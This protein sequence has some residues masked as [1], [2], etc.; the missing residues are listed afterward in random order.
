[1]RA[2]MPNMRQIAPPITASTR[3]A[4]YPFTH[5]IT[6]APDGMRNSQMIENMTKSGDRLVEAARQ[7]VLAYAE[8]NPMRQADFHKATCGCLRCEIDRLDYEADQYEEAMLAARGE[9][10]P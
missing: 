4:R 2:G 5:A 7:A 10:Q 8:Q 1:M 6:R 3:T 9:A